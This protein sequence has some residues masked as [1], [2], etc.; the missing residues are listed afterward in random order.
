MADSR[1]TVGILALQGDTSLH[2]QA[3]AK[4]GLSAKFVKKPEDFDD[5]EGLIIPGGESTTLL[6]L[7]ESLGLLD[8]ISE[9]AKNGGRIF[10]TCAGAILLAKK[11]FNP[12]QPSLGLIDI[13]IERNAY[14]RQLDSFE[15]YGHGLPPLPKR[16]KMTFIRA[17]RI[18][19]TGPDTKILATHNQEPVLVRQGSI[20]VSTFHPEL[21]DQSSIYRYWL[22]TEERAKI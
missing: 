21:N 16:I 13:E 3:L 7:A 22:E 11:V 6:Y 20:L 12:S 9:F 2:S 10:G 14:G 18:I 5:I 4:L 1:G 8:K 19:L 15:E 17:P